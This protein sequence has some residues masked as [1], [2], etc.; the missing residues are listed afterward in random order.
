M[1]VSGFGHA[2]ISERGGMIQL[3]G[4]ILR[5]STNEASNYHNFMHYYYTVLSSID[6]QR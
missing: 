1:R 4:I 3:G 5:L 6:L 2:Q